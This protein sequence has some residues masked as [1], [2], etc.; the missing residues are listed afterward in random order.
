MRSFDAPIRNCPGCNGGAPPTRTSSSNILLPPPHRRRLALAYPQ[1]ATLPTLRGP[2]VQLQFNS[3]PPR[4]GSPPILPPVENGPSTY[5]LPTT[6]RLFR[7]RGTPRE[8]RRQQDLRH[9]HPPRGARSSHRRNSQ[10]AR[11][12][13]PIPVPQQHQ[14][15]KRILLR[16]LTR[17]HQR[18]VPRQSTITPGPL[19]PHPRHAPLR[20][21]HRPARPRDRNAP[22]ISRRATG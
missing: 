1:I 7:H 21:T 8:N 5:P 22:S 14:A 11:A 15:R 17:N 12:S 13:R 2:R 20:K 10:Q 4:R 6:P 3:L 19:S 9:L 16:N 18:P